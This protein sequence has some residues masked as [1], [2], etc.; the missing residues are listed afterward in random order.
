MPTEAGSLPLEF[1]PGRAPHSGTQQVGSWLDAGHEA[2][3]QG[4]W[5]AARTCFSMALA[6]DAGPEPLHGMARTVEWAGDF[7]SAI[8]YYEAAYAAYRRRGEVRAPAVI[9]ARELG[10]LHAA[11][12]GNEAAAAGWLARGIRLAREAGECSEAGWVDL[13]CCLAADS[14]DRLAVHAAAAAATARPLADP[15]LEFCA[16]SYEG[17]GLVL[18]GKVADGMRR[19]DEAAAAATGGEGREYQAVGEIYC[20]VLLCSEM[21]LDVRRAEEWIG[22]ATAFGHRNNALWIPAICGMH[23]GSILVAAGQWEQAE[24]R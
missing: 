23:Y 20:K 16:L 21:T 15:Y 19:I 4:N 10:F 2:L 7:D 13:A 3:E 5:N 12:Y 22:I 17:L 8:R 11:V 1:P 9:A 18:T 14:P 6:V 24:H